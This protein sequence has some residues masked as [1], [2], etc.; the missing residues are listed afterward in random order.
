MRP[1]LRE[2][3]LLN[4]RASVATVRLCIGSDYHRGGYAVA[5]LHVQQADALGV[6]SRLADCRRVHADDFAV[7]ADQHDFGSLVDLCD[8]DYLS[9]ALS[10]LHV[11][12]TF[13][14]AVGEA[15]FVG[16]RALA[17]SVLGD[18]EN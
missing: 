14:A 9:H 5:R 12:D 6:A 18:G 15:I 16:G 17:V 13:A 8:R 3:W 2:S 4:Q 11:D 10:R 7:V 1:S